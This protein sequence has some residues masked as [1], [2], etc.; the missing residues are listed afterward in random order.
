MNELIHAHRQPLHVIAKFQLRHNPAAT[1]IRTASWHFVHELFGDRCWSGHRVCSNLDPLSHMPRT[2]SQTFFGS[3]YSL[4]YST[5]FASNRK[6]DFP[7][8]SC[9][10]GARRRYSFYSKKIFFKADRRTRRSLTTEILCLTDIPEEQKR[11]SRTELQAVQLNT[12]RSISERA[13]TTEFLPIKSVSV[14][15]VVR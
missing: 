10:R 15:V 8:H 12:C 4:S 6:T 3:R 14:S 1:L 5:R 9:F 11:L 2:P 7:L 13:A